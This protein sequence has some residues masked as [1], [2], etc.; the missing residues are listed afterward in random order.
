[1]LGGDVGSGDE[2]A[3]SALPPATLDD[4]T[5]EAVDLRPWI[6]YWKP[7]ITIAVVDDFGPHAPGKL[8]PYFEKL[9]QLDTT[10]R[11]FFPLVTLSE[12]WLLKDKMVPLN[13]TV[14]GV[15]LHLDVTTLS[16]WWLQMQM[17][18]E[19]S[20]EMQ[21]KGG[22]MQARKGWHVSPQRATAA[23]PTL[24]SRL[25]ASA[26]RH[27]SSAPMPLDPPQP[28]RTARATT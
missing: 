13:A 28:C 5:P 20:F 26:P 18:M 19:Q 24:L 12:F 27:S 4:P 17:A 15:D 3:A 14:G 8:P 2:A 9:A 16:A 6:P 1:L 10:T 25:P 7:N 11:S 23:V 21:S 22:M